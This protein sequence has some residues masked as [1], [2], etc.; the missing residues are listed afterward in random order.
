MMQLILPVLETHLAP[1]DTIIL[2]VSGGPDSTALLKALVEFYKINPY[3]QYSTFNIPVIVAHVNHGIRGAAA[4]RDEKFTKALAKANNLR[5]EIKRVKLRGSGLEEQGRNV[6]REFFEQLRKKYSARWIVTAHTEDDQLETIIFNFLRGSGPAGLAGMQ[7]TN[8]FYF[9]PLLAM[10]KSAILAFL[11]SQKQPFCNDE[12]NSDTKLSRVL[13]RKKIIPLMLKINPSLRQTLSRESK[14]FREIDGW[15]KIFA[16]DFLNKQNA[17]TANSTT[18][19]FSLKDYKKL[20]E[21]LRYA[22]I[23]E[24]HRDLPAGKKKSY[25]LPMVKILEIA[26]MLDRGIGNKR[27]MCGDRGGTF[28]LK[29]GR[30]VITKAA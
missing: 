11:K 17:R 30:V 29:K 1:G 3:I 23:Q 27:I 16:A 22:V 2:G 19:S 10:P 14:L 24:S 6:R 8:G 4:L 26:K 9:K 28:A 7:V 18:N 20:P 13:I 25:A 5:C 12:M 15:L 21:A